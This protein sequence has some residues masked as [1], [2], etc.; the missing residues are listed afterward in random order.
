MYVYESEQ[1]I[2]ICIYTYISEVEEMLLHEQSASAAI[3]ANVYT[4]YLHVR[5]QWA[6]AT[7]A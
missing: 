3:S 1:E 7:P 6:T 5:W 2:Y 4:A